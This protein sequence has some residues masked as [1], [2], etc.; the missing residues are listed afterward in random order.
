MQVNDSAEKQS[1]LHGEPEPDEAR[2]HL[3]SAR[4]SLVKALQSLDSIDGTAHLAAR[5]QE[6]I[7]LIDSE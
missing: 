6:V 2:A 4:A 1:I 7:D 5:C 3:D